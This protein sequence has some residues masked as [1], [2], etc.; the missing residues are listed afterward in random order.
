MARFEN[1]QIRKFGKHYVL[2][3]A[4]AHRQKHA[5]TEIAYIVYSYLLLEILIG[6]VSYDYEVDVSLWMMAMNR[7]IAS[8][9]HLKYDVRAPAHTQ[10]F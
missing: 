9:L 1:G 5:T 4:K 10:L 7:I 3:K 2:I 6:V 8:F